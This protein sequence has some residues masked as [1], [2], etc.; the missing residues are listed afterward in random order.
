HL[1]QFLPFNKIFQKSRD[2]YDNLILFLTFSLDVSLYNFSVVKNHAEVLSTAVEM[3][4]R[5]KMVL[6]INNYAV[7]PSSLLE[8]NLQPLR[9]EKI[10]ILR[11]KLKTAKDIYQKE[12]NQIRA[13]TY[14]RQNALFKMLEKTKITAKTHCVDASDN[15]TRFVCVYYEITSHGTL[16][17][18]CTQKTLENFA[19][20][21]FDPLS[22]CAGDIISFSKKCYLPDLIPILNRMRDTITREYSITNQE[23]IMCIDFLIERVAFIG[24]FKR[25]RPV[26]A[27]QDPTFSNDEILSRQQ[28]ERFE[29]CDEVLKKK[30]MLL[31]R[32][33]NDFTWNGDFHSE[34]GECSGLEVIRTPLDVFDIVDCIVANVPQHAKRQPDADEL[35]QHVAW[36]IA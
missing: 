23:H 32:C 9:S 20:W 4:N 5:N 16:K 35:L 17:Y 1:I 10:E 26:T 8:D 22:P 3:L 30:R 34:I 12:L 11:L 27:C 2:Y 24:F 28:V 19:L 14:P 31:K 7:T 21:L 18:A 13:I 25:C 6:E 29:D 33:W 36:I 15:Q